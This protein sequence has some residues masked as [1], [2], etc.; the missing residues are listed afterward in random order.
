MCE[1]GQALLRELRILQA[2][3]YDIKC[4][5]YLSDAHGISGYRFEKN[6]SFLSKLSVQFDN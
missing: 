2:G 6:G 3:L 4:N 5:S 1:I